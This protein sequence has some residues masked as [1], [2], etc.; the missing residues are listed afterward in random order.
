MSDRNGGQLLP[1]DLV[2]INR[3]V[4][5][6]GDTNATNVVL[7]D[8][9]TNL[10]NITNVEINTEPAGVLATIGATSLQLR[11][12]TGASA[13]SGGTIAPAD[14]PIFVSYT[15]TVVES[16]TGTMA[17]A[18]ATVTYD[19][20]QSVPSEASLPLAP[21][22]SDPN[23]SVNKSHAGN[24]TQG[25]TGTYAIDVAN[26]ANAGPTTG[27]VT[28]ADTLPAGLTPTAASGTGWNC[29]IS[30]QTVTCTRSDALAAGASYPTINVTTNVTTS[31]P[32]TFTNT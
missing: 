9:L 18:V 7:T 21:P 22:A 10:S 8:Q 3:T 13:A 5:N 17:S 19:G 15:A 27:T 30:G 2:D 31:A 14:L 12:G 16:P 23:L 4:D 6:T 25:G 29:G 32:C 11:L 28:V 24:F 20:G 1:G 26:T